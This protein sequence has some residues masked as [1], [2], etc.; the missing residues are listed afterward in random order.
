MRGKRVQ[1]PTPQV[2]NIMKGNRQ[3]N[4]RLELAVR[5]ELWR[6]GYRGYRVNYKKLPGKPD[7]VYPSQKLVVFIHGCFWHSCP[8][9]NRSQ[10]K[11]NA[12]FW[13]E[14]FTQNKKRDAVVVEKIE[15]LGWRVLI[16]WECEIQKEFQSSF[17]RIE[18]ALFGN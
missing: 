16:I 12:A 9:C 7:I 14:K 13:R 10:P 17:N 1:K 18:Q 11:K 8:K 5:K 4:T 6:R 2:S 3:A 15:T